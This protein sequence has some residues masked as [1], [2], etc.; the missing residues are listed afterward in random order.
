MLAKF[1]YH[2]N[3][4]LGVCDRH[5]EMVSSS[6]KNGGLADSETLNIPYSPCFPYRINSNDIVT[7]SSSVF[8]HLAR[9]IHF[10]GLDVEL[11]ERAELLSDIRWERD[12]DKTGD[13]QFMDFV[14]ERASECALNMRTWLFNCNLHE[15]SISTNKQL[16]TVN[17]YFYFF[18]KIF[19]YWVFF[20]II[21]L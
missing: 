6:T 1:Q 16:C 14:M 18:F 12:C 21:F 13:T 17:P 3:V 10:A 20:L 8:R 11:L 19:I 9:N 15:L 4:P 5:T 2:T 7:G